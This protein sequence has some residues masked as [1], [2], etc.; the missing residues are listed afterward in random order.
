MGSRSRSF[1]RS[2]PSPTRRYRSRSRY[3][4]T[5]SRSRSESSSGSYSSYSDLRSRSRDSYDR[6]SRHRRHRS[7]HRSPH[8]RRRHRHRHPRHRRSRSSYSRSASRSRSAERRG[9]A[10]RSNGSLAKKHSSPVGQSKVPSGP[11][12]T[13]Q[14]SQSQGP[15][16]PS[17]P[18]RDGGHH[19]L[20][21]SQQNGS[22]DNQGTR[23]GRGHY[24]E[25]SGMV[26]QLYSLCSVLPPSDYY[27]FDVLCNVD[28]EQV[29]RISQLRVYFNFYFILVFSILF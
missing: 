20:D 8:T 5:R 22:L 27:R 25:F 17:D 1:S 13:D 7:H 2:R 4:Q 29:I 16:K 3:N 21:P 10:R 28:F 15:G 12:A 14:S 26:A 23:C 9:S 11:T 18:P 24:I 6:Y 19:A